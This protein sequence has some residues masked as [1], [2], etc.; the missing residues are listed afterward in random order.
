MRAEEFAGAM[1]GDRGSGTR[2]DQWASVPAG[3][4]SSA[5]RKT[6]RRRPQIAFFDYSDVFEDFY[7]HYGVDQKA[8]ATRWV[9]T[10]SHA[11]LS[12]LQRE[13]GDVVWYAFSVAPQLDEARH[14]V[15]G[16][17]IRILP[18]SWLHRRLWRAFYLPRLA[19]CWRA[20]YPAY[21]VVA[22]Y[23]ALAS[24]PFVRMLWRDRPDILFVQDYATGRYDVLVAI[25]RAL[26]IPVIAYHAGSR[27]ERYVGRLAKRWSIPAADRL[28]VSSHAEREMLARRYQVATDRLALILTPIDTDT[29][30]PIDRATACRAAQLDATRRHLLFVGRLDDHVKRVSALIESFAA[31]AGA[32]PD[33]DLLIVG[34]GRE[35]PDLERLAGHKA[36]GRVRFIG[37]VSEPDRLAAFYNAAEC[38]V[39]PSRSEG[40]PTVVGEAM[41]CG[42]PVAGSRVGGVGELVVEGE[43]GWLLPSGDDEALTS[44]L[45]AILTDREAVAAMRPRAR[46]MAEAR[47]APSVVA[48]ELRRCFR[49]DNGRAEPLPDDTGPTMDRSRRQASR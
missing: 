20:A 6:P 8:F 18:S 9:G 32:A 36:P 34:A 15:I 29:F 7:P 35:R 2:R 40:F 33:A 16:C 43:T 14:E 19:W 4:P 24:A 25:A 11:F 47:V 12:L 30:R 27:P 41:A 37:W 26:G 23:V 38:L 42:T 3:V 5:A 48:A 10:G 22:S 31:V 45:A 44:A 13:V 1:G 39:L 17:Q 28:I 21:A 49:V 46:R